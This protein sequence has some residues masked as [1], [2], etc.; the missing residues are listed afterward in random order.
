MLKQWNFEYFKMTTQVLKDHSPNEAH[1]NTNDLKSIDRLSEKDRKLKS[2]VWCNDVYS[3]V[4]E[5]PVTLRVSCK[6]ALQKHFC[7]HRLSQEDVHKYMQCLVETERIPR[8]IA[9]YICSTYIPIEPRLHLWSKSCSCSSQVKCFNCTTQKDEYS[10]SYNDCHI[11]SSILGMLPLSWFCAGQ[12]MSHMMG[13]CAETSR[14]DLFTIVP[15]WF[16]V[17]YFQELLPKM[18][19]LRCPLTSK[20]TQGIFWHCTSGNLEIIPEMQHRNGTAR[21]Y[22]N[23]LSSVEM[24]YERTL[25]MQSNLGDMIWSYM[26]TVDLRLF[27]VVGVHMPYTQSSKS[28]TLNSMFHSKKEDGEINM[29]ICRLQ[30][31]CPLT[32]IQYDLLSEFVAKLNTYLDTDLFS[33]SCIVDLIR[34][35]PEIQQYTAVLLLELSGKSTLSQFQTKCIVQWK[36]YRVCNWIQN[37]LSLLKECANGSRTIIDEEH[38]SVGRAFFLRDIKM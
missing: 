21:I 8:M 5:C 1:Y 17:K 13:D 4:K 27:Q 38:V 31:Y 25:L 7:Q 26:R 28:V 10:R 30:S 19:Y 37:I 24:D 6:H 16:D 18:W 11:L 36:R 32:D 22:L 3:R 9:H 15:R 23:F 14:I 2:E 29:D 34:K 35:Y 20:Y 33:V 12:F